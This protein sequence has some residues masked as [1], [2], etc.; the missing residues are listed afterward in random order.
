MKVAKRRGRPPKNPAL[1]KDNQPEV[2]APEVSKDHGNGSAS[3]AVNGNGQPRNHIAELE[4]RVRDRVDSWETE[5]L[6]ED[7]I[8]GLAEETSFPDDGK[9]YHWL[10]NPYISTCVAYGP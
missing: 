2:Q 3:V 8:E 10:F 1:K 5:S 6:Y 9:Y 4:E 7:A